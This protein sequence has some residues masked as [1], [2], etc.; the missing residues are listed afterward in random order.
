MA[1]TTTT[2]LGLTKPEVGASTD[3]WGTKINTDLDT[4]DAVFKGDGTGTAFGATST[5]N[6]VLYLN[7]TKKL[8]SGSALVF[9]GSNLGLGVTPS[10][11]SSSAKAL[12]IGIYAGFYRNASGITAM[13]FNSYQNT[14]NND[15][16]R[17]SSNPATKYEMA[18]SHAWYVAPSGTAGNAITFT[19]AMT[20]DASGRLIVGATSVSGSNQV[21]IQTG[22]TNGLWVQSGST[23]SSNYVA[24][25]RTGTNASVL[26]LRADNTA[27]VSGN[28]L[29][30]TTGTAYGSDE[31]LSV[32][33]SGGGSGTTGAGIRGLNAVLLGL[34]NS[35]VGSSTIIGFSAGSSG[36]G[37]GSITTNGTSTVAYNT[38]SDYRLK[39]NVQPMTGALA[40]IS[41]LKPVTYKWKV[42]G[43]DGQGFIAHELQE[44]VPD[45]VNGEKDAVDADG[46]P[47]YQGIDTSFL[48]ATL[49]AAIQEQQAII[50]S[51]SVAIEAL[52]ARLDAAN[53]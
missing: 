42:D 50:E 12:E 13:S 6:A 51:Q 5:A 14:S 40:K 37:V 19:Q 44:V 24:D 49:T 10:A 27:L 30:G 52:K 46:N 43:S 39:E 16:Y 31:R 8:T 26:A 28:L 23:S 48:V 47:V 35:T 17:V 53:L 2:N 3:T 21:E 41:A 32:V 29:V 36:A 33:T 34:W 15:T 1:D 20:L 7:G 9:D 38:S 25:F 4:I 45:C 22:L 11:W 18:G